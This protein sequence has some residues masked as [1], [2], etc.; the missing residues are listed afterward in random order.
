MK[1][2][3]KKKN[4]TQMKPRRLKNVFSK[5]KLVSMKKETSKY[6]AHEKDKHKEHSYLKVT[7][8]EITSDFYTYI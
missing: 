7:F 4:P 3:G 1:K 8:L 5:I 6:I 2:E